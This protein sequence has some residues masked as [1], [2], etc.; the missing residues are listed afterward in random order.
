MNLKFT[1][2]SNRCL[3]LTGSTGCRAAQPDRG[4][5]AFCRGLKL[6]A[7]FGFLIVGIVHGSHLPPT[8]PVLPGSDHRHEDHSG[9]DYTG[10][11]LS[12]VDFSAASLRDA[13]LLDA[14]VDGA[15]FVDADMRNAILWN[16]SIGQA[17]FSGAD[18]RGARLRNMVGA[19]PVFV[20]ADLSG[21]DMDDT[22]LEFADM[23]NVTFSGANLAEFT[24]FRTNFRG[25]NL[26]SAL[27]IDAHTEAL[28]DNATLL[29]PGF[30][31]VE[32][33]WHFVPEPSTLAMMLA[34]LPL[35]HLAYRRR[36]SLSNS[37]RPEPPTC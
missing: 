35:A 20:G 21:V 30:D 33:G 16:A 6:C 18:L 7:L 19:G 4:R 5:A 14:L 37:L 17:D 25:A 36:R 26:S 28:Y 34:A 13:N 9:A 1:S 2:A 8:T 27:G 12:Q 3:T 10:L 23:R 22:R 32:A 15:R 24:S 31:P 29:P 11:N